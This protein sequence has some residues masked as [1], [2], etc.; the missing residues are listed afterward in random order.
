LKQLQ[1][2]Y[3]RQSSVSQLPSA[4]RDDNARVERAPFI[5]GLAPAKNRSEAIDAIP[6]PLIVFKEVA[7]D[8]VGRTDEPKFDE[9]EINTR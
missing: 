8:L 3:L 5:V 9:E 1:I 7:G 2:N 4:W 6:L